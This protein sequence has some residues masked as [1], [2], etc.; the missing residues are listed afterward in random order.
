MSK[1]AH[2]NRLLR[3][4]ALSIALCYGWMCLVVSFQHTH[5]APVEARES[6]PVRFASTEKQANTPTTQLKAATRTTP[7]AACEWDA[8]NVSP[9][10][11][12]FVLTFETPRT[13]RVITTFPRYLPSLAFSTSSRGPP[14]A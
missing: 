4:F 13:P 8:A 7:C 10:L 5:F 3:V 1:A 9:A 6:A 11:P 14:L 2:A 12:A